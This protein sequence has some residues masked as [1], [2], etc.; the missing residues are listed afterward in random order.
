M[1][2]HDGL[3][4]TVMDQYVLRTIGVPT[5]VGKSSDGVGKCSDGSLEASMDQ[6]VLHAIGVPTH[7]GKSSDAQPESSN[8][9]RGTF[10][11]QYVLHATSV[12]TPRRG[13]PT[14]RLKVPTDCWSQPWIGTF[15]RQSVFQR[16]TEKLRRPRRK[17]ERIVG[18]AA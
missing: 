3:H 2:K 18:S 10:M 17:F 11:D 15:H 12:S 16:L 8:G 14:D 13:F 9:F 7:V 6:Y 4:G 5:H 1:E